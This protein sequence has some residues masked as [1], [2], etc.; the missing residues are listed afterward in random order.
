MVAGCANAVVDA[1]SQLIKNRYYFILLLT[2]Y[3]ILEA[4]NPCNSFRA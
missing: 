1:M 3:R 2:S 4:E